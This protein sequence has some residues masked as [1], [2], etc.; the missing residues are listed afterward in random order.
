MRFKKIISFLVIILFILFP[1]LA[2][3]ETPGGATLPVSADGLLPADCLTTEG[4]TLCNFI[5]L[6]IN[7]SNILLALSGTFA[8]LMFVFG[9]ILMI[10]AYGNESRV[11][12]GKD[13]L[14]ATV[15]GIFIVLFAW[16]IVNLMIGALTGNPS[17]DWANINKDGVCSGQK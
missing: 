12:W 11:K 7:A 14:V 8:I 5:D 4:C 9:G 1:V 13:V 10:T 15:V 17:S 2:S 3:A 6:F 16:T